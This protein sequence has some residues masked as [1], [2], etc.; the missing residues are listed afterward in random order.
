MKH[1]PN[2][3]GPPDVSPA[4]LDVS[5][6]VPAYQA[7]ETIGR[8]LSSIAAQSSKP[9]EII[10][11]D[12]GSDDATADIAETFRPQFENCRFL[13][14]SQ[15][16]QG[17]GAAR[18]AGLRE[19]S[20][21]LVAFLD[22]DDEWFSSH[23]ASTVS[24][25]NA[26]GLTLAAHNEILVVDGKES[27]NDS[28]SRLHERADPYI[29]LYRKGCVSTS[30]VIARRDAIVR[31]GGFDPQLS[32]G[33]D[34]D[35]WLALLCQPGATFD[36]FEQPLSRYYILS[37]SV[38]S[39]ITKRHYFFMKIARRWAGEIVSRKDGVLS[40]LWFRI[41]AIHYESFKG[42]WNNANFLAAL[43]VCIKYPFNMVEI[44]VRGLLKT[45]SN[46]I[47]LLQ[48]STRNTKANNNG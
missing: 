44:S 30:T 39:N 11:V 29:A 16:N 42:H 15:S 32:N 41:S 27:L 14:I 2:S 26:D 20:C 23:L 36:L 5:V 40:D 7:A 12:D 21:E 24:R 10:V 18:N 37:G 25:L 46:R 6:I 22:A 43:L 17:P 19:A 9:K 28:L 4:F 48:P 31:V 47:L 34:V 3:P 13:V 1:Y 8:A 38:N 35:L 33:Q 45:S